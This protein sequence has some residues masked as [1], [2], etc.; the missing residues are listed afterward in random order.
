MRY[1]VRIKNRRLVEGLLRNRAI[2]FMDNISVK[3]TEES[4]NIYIDKSLIY[5]LP[6]EIKPYHNN[7]WQGLERHNPF[8]IGTMCRMEFPFKGYVLGLIDVFGLLCDKYNICLY[9]VGDG[10]NVAQLKEK[11]DTIPEIVR[12]R[13]EYKKSVDYTKID[14]FYCQCDL[15][16]GMGTMLLDAA[17]NNVLAMPVS[18]YCNELKVSTV[19]SENIEKLFRVGK[20]CDFEEKLKELLSLSQGDYNALIK[21]QYEKVKKT[22]GI[23]HFCKLLIDS[24]FGIIKLKRRDRILFDILAII[25]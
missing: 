8:A 3:E 17:N 16:L 22:Y 7:Y 21:D 10:P 9:I 18:G 12:N 5:Y 19:F 4:L 15:V 13:I 6:I 1:Y 20:E 2:V 14:S 23:D 25:R 24:S 11:L